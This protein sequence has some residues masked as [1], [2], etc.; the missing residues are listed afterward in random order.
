MQLTGIIVI[1]AL[2]ALLM[3]SA[4]L[5]LGRPPKRGVGR[6]TSPFGDPTR[7]FRDPYR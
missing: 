6:T 3:G 4:Y 5:F 7:G 2:I 1:T